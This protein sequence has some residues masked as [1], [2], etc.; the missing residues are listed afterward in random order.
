MS[1]GVR[2]RRGVRWYRNIADKVIKFRGEFADADSLFLTVSCR[3]PS[4]RHFSTNRKYRAFSISLTFLILVTAGG[5]VKYMA[6]INA[7]RLQAMRKD[8]QITSSTLAE[9]VN[10]T[11]RCIRDLE[12]GRKSNPSALVLYN[13]SRALGVSMEYLIEDPDTAPKKI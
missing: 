10:T 7:L 1:F 9:K 5:E 8:M 6:K 4:L 3:L 11:V 13:I 2:L 12:K